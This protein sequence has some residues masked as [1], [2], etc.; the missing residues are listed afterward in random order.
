MET[1]TTTI[2]CRLPQH[3]RL[4]ALTVTRTQSCSNVTVPYLV[5][6]APHHRQHRVQKS[7]ACQEIGNNS[8][9]AMTRNLMRNHWCCVSGNVSHGKSLS[10][11]VPHHGGAHLQQKMKG[12][13]AMHIGSSSG[14]GSSGI[15][16]ERTLPVMHLRRG[17]AGDLFE[18]RAVL[19]IMD[20]D[21][22]APAITVHPLTRIVAEARP[23]TYREVGPQSQR[24]HPIPGARVVPS[25][26]ALRFLGQSGPHRH[27]PLGQAC[28][29]T[30][31]PT[32]RFRKWE[33]HQCRCQEAYQH[34]GLRVT[35]AHLH[36]L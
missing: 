33:A 1:T 21:G 31:I 28:A 34:L 19:H 32:S 26:V 14:P 17:H 23:L 4:A 18:P 8:R 5:A 10:R 11:G 6:A 25:G 24:D 20:G 29:H 27:R 36:N 13:S 12:Q 35:G 7:G 15:G 2:H 22:G 9:H 30:W 3:R 16:G